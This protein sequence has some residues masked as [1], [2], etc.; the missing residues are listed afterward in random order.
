MQARGA[1]I[2]LIDEKMA[3]GEGM[4]EDLIASYDSLKQT[5]LT[6]MSDEA[7]RSSVEAMFRMLPAFLFL[8]CSIPAYLAQRSLN[9]AYTTNGMSR[10]VTAESEFFTMSL[11]SAVIY[12]VSLFLFMLPVREMEFVGMVAGNL[13]LIL[14]PGMLL[15]GLR[16]FKQQ[17][18]ARRA[19][20]RW[21]VILL[22][23]AMLIFATSG[24]LY[25]GGF[26]GA[27]MRIM[28]AIQKAIKKKMGQGH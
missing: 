10:V 11:P 23:I 3:A 25:L 4:T 7:I 16:Y 24:M 2:A 6:L 28:Q 27:Y 26:F 9:A 19:G 15:L 13:S 21:L 22:V 1:L 14:L 12:T 5:F 8:G 20:S 18:G 17:F